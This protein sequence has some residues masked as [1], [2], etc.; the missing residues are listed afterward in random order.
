MGCRRIRV[1][2]PF[3]YIGSLKSIWATLDLSSKEEKGWGGKTVAK[4]VALIVEQLWKT[5]MGHLSSAE[6]VLAM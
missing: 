4:G 2:E 1:S 5:N 3:L 6:A